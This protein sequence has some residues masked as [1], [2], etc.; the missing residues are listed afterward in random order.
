MLALTTSAVGSRSPKY[1][2]RVLAPF[3]GREGRGMH[4]HHEHAFHPAPC[5]PSCGEAMR[6]FVRLIPKIGGLAELQTFVARVLFRRSPHPC[7][8]AG[9]GWILYKVILR[10][11]MFDRGMRGPH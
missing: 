4:D 9:T 7:A 11:D 2:H 3:G 1:G 8:R 6:R 10:T 5:C